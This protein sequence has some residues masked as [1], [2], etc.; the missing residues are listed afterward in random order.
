[1]ENKNVASAKIEVDTKEAREN[2]KEL[3]NDASE[4]MAA[5]EKLEK[6]MGKFTRQTPV[7]MPNLKPMMKQMSANPID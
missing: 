1:M 3:T 4:C 5:L 7:K 6:V 2:I